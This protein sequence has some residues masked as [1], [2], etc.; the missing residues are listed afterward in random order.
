LPELFNSGYQFI[1]K[2]DVKRFAEAVPQGFTTQA[3]HSVAKEKGFYIV[4]GLAEKDRFQIYN[5]AVLIGPS[6]HIATYRKSHLFFEEK[7]W[8]TPGD[9]GFMVHDIGFAKIGMM[10]CFDWIFPEVTRI[11]ALKGAQ[12]LCQPA[13][14]IFTLCHKTMVARAIE[15]RIFTITANRVGLE[16]RNGKKPLTFT[17]LSQIVD[18]NGN[19]L[20]QLSSDREETRIIEIDPNRALDKMFTEYNNLMEDRRVD[21]YREIID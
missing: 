1:S 15:N 12:I 14:L 20:F 21:L 16:Q 17:G 11:L 4:A 5:S 13:N 6:G 8:F 10:V 7:L 18:S 3:L 9:T 2:E 19:C